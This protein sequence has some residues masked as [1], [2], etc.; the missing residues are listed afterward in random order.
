MFHVAQGGA[1]Q[2][3][4]EFPVVFDGAVQEFTYVANILQVLDTVVCRLFIYFI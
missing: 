3:V 2:V 1:E 4:S